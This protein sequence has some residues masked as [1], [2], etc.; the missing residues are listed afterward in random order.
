MGESPR[1]QLMATT[2]AMPASTP[3]PPTSSRVSRVASGRAL[4]ALAATPVL[5]AIASSGVGGSGD[6]GGGDS[7]ST[8]VRAAI[9]MPAHF[10]R[11]L[12]PVA[13]AAVTKRCGDF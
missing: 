3:A 2:K 5:A 4:T 6:E 13:R 7:D 11:G 8:P 10:S 12:H 1:S 9:E